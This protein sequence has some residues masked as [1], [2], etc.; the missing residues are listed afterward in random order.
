[1][2]VDAAAGVHEWYVLR[3][4]RQ[5]GPYPLSVLIE[6][7]KKGIITSDDLIWRPS[8]E[9]WR[10][11]T[12]V[13]GLFSP[14]AKNSIS[15]EIAIY[16]DHA[17]IASIAQI[18]PT[19]FAGPSQQPNNEKSP[20]KSRNYF[21]RHWRGELSLPVSYWINNILSVLLIYA[22]AAPLVA[23]VGDGR[24][25][26]NGSIAAAYSLYFIT[27]LA[28]SLWQL[29]G[30]WRSATH[31]PSR[32][33]KAFWAGVVKLLVVV[34]AIRMSTDFGTFFWPI[35]SENAR[36][37]FGDE[38]FGA[39][40]F[41]LLRNGTELEFS[42][43]INVGVAKEFSQMIDAASQV[44]VL[45]LN[46]NGGRIAEA[47]LMASKVRQRGLTTYVSEECDSAC[48]HIF[49]AGKQRW[50]STHATVGFHRPDFPGLKTEDLLPIV[51]EE[52]RQLIS[53]GL[54]ADFVS[55]VLTTP[56]SSMWRPTADELV[57]AHVISG[58]VDNTQFAASGNF[59]SLAVDPNRIAQTLVRT[60][61]Y[62]TL[63][64]V[65]PA[66]FTSMLHELSEGYA[67]GETEEQIFSSAR[68]IFAKSLSRYLATAS[69]EDLLQL[70][71]IYVSY[72]D[73]LKTIDP[74]SCVALM[75]D[76]KGAR[77]KVSLIEAFPNIGNRELLLYEAIISAGTNGRVSR[78]TE[79]QA[80]KTMQSIFSKPT[81][82]KDKVAIF[83]KTS[84]L[85]E[86]YKSF[87]EVAFAF[88]GEVGRLPKQQ[89]ANL[90]RY[91]YANN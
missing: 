56:S 37:A 67:Q 6:G 53:F 76:S 28:I 51:E 70:N 74:E 71:A 59:A 48:T 85:P 25:A 21:I 20:S 33:G 15:R 26:G 84:L 45:H 81:F 7:A 65:D 82:G 91:L 44:K 30:V 36:I 58:V 42:G 8:W 57:T 60:P 66:T 69:D 68:L 2:D 46:S 55:K 75:D 13:V 5:Y 4:Q 35:I 27:A 63:Q 80:T 87:C 16:S 11:A 78:F 62:A 50:I 24:T 64:R 79:T 29:I 14:Q 77:M 32:G 22:L 34:A 1:M 47:D 72:M 43:G 9:N 3:D 23:F 18:I 54:P 86:E 52:R 41:R 89:A 83:L 49:L 12:A 17:Q 61:L 39:H 19:P 73:G 88:F 31:H 10:K 90:L 40:S 38:K